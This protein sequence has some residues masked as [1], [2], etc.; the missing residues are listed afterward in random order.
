MCFSNGI[1]R[2]ATPLP[3]GRV[4]G[5]VHPESVTL[6]GRDVGQKGMPDEPVD[7]GGNTILVSPAAP[8]SL[9]S[10]RHSSRRSATPLNT[11]KLVPEPS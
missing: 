2:G 8:S 7:F 10:N 6:S 5:A 3:T 1:A 11:A 9:L 4:V